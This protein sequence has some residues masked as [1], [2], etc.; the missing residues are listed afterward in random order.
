M[1]QIR[2]HSRAGQGAIT[3]A[4][5]LCEIVGL[6]HPDLHTQAFPDYGA[7]KKGAPV[8]V[9]NRFS[10]SEILLRNHIEHPD[11]VVLLDTTLINDSELSYDDI[12]EGTTK[13]STLLLNTKQKKT[14][15]SEKFLGNIYHIDATGIA[16]DEIKKNI[17]NV[18]MLGSLIQI[19]HLSPLEMF[20]NQLKE[21]LLNGLP[22]KIVEGNMHAFLR[23]AKEYWKVQ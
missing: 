21:Y 5:A 10:K 20:A 1:Y 8:V 2:W 22:A 19:S 9:F 15:F 14:K 13:N 16:T 11:L 23:G 3:V 4:N 6:A 17:P 12:M 7:E 18:P